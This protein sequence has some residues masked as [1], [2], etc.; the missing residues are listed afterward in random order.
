MYSGE[1]LTR[2]HSL[3]SLIKINFI[4]VNSIQDTLD[5]VQRML[6]DQQQKVQTMSLNLSTSQVNK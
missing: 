6:Q 5:S 3:T 4:L 2:L 1:Y